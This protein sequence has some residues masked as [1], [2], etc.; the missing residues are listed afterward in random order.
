MVTEGDI[1]AV[2]YIPTPC[3]CP[4]HSAHQALPLPHKRGLDCPVEVGAS[5]NATNADSAHVDGH[6]ST[7][8]HTVSLPSTLPVMPAA[9]LTT[10]W[11]PWLPGGA[12]KSKSMA[13]TGA[14][15]YRNKPESTLISTPTQQ[16]TC[17]LPNETNGLTK[18][19]VPGARIEVQAAQEQR[20]HWLCQGA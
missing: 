3:T 15:A 6:G 18:A 13:S 1:V 16:P 19:M 8:D 20:R 17:T 10:Q 4:T 11:R 9:R 5:Y 12:W 7:R 2:Q 14:D